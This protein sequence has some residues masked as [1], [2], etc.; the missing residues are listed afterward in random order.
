[1]KKINDKLPPIKKLKLSK[2][3]QEKEDNIKINLQMA[4]QLG[5]TGNFKWIGISLSGLIQEI[6][7]D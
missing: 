4:N 5:M 6:V 2:T 3:S 7:V 1:M